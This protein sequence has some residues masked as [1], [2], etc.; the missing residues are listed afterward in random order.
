L[1]SEWFREQV[2]G[3]G[4]DL[5]RDFRPL[6]LYSL[7]FLLLSG[8]VL[9]PL[10]TWALT[11]LVSAS[12]ELSV[13]NQEILHFL[14][15]PKGIIFLLLG[16]VGSAAILFAEQA[17][18][19]LI[20]WESRRGRRLHAVGALWSITLRL[21]GLALLG[22]LHIGAHLLLLAPFL[23][24]GACT[25]LF[26]LSS[27]DPYYLITQKPPVWW[28]SLGIALLLAL[29][30]LI[31]NGGLFLR[32]VFSLPAFLLEGLKPRDSLGRSRS[33]MRGCRWRVAIFLLGSMLALA[34]LPGLLTG[35]FYLLGRGIFALLPLKFGLVF[36]LVLILLALY[37]LA[38]ALVLFLGVAGNS[39]VLIRLY[40]DVRVGG[41]ED[42]PDVAVEARGAEAAPPPPATRPVSWG[43]VAILLIVA[44]VAS[45]FV[46]R[47]LELKVDVQITAHRGSSRA[48]PENTLS[49]ISRAIEDGADYAEI[50]V[51]ETADGKIVVIHDKDLLRIAGL[52]RNI[53]EVR[54]DEIKDLD[55]GSWFHPD[56]RGERIPL[57]E[58]AIDLA[59]DRIRLNIE[60]KYNGHDRQLPE[61]VVE[62]IERTDFVSRC[63]LTSLNYEGL[64]RVR[65]LNPRIQ[66]G[67]IVFQ[68]IGRIEQRNVDF[69]SVAGGMATSD[70]IFYA[71]RAGKDVH[72]WTVNEREEMLRF[73][74]LGADN[75]ITDRPG[76]ARN[77]LKEISG[78]SKEERL[79]LKVRSWLLR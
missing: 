16:G 28:V 79:L 55:A 50:D 53:W 35:L 64:L 68:S 17:G 52:K 13:G 33:L 1:K 51:Q 41:E 12:G 54:Y 45:W 72:V 66:T 49:A 47:G 27:Y 19:L 8:A 46:L 74:D 67:Y 60:L 44:L 11:S 65:E 4:Q 61:R 23:A 21:P 10:L 69:L 3:V 5:R 32:W 42:V 62:I 73:I 48:A 24:A 22:F 36:P 71:H 59:R 37:L 29:G 2:R 58:Q 18:I 75:L 9:T 63:T 34:I 56:F 31:L 30:I 6:L 70:L 14:L 25:Y 57:L 39:L 15:S 77:L 43:I 40:T 7:F 78:L 76:E 20:A 38:S 26:L